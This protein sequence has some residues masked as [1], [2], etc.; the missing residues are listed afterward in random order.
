MF[1]IE[2]R[3]L[4]YKHRH[5]FVGTASLDD[6]LGRLDFSATQRTMRS[7]VV[8]AF[9]HLASTEQ[10]LARK[11]SPTPKG[12]EFVQRTISDT[13]PASDDYLMHAQVK[14]GIITLQGFL[15]MVPWDDQDQADTMSVVDAF[16]AASHLDQTLSRQSKARAFRSWVVREKLGRGTNE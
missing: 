1:E 6:F 3:D 13:V 5:T 7:T 10:I 11:S 8:K 15:D 12:W 16:C 4:E 2:E 14:L 9:I